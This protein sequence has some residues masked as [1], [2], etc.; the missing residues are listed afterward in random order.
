MLD[1]ANKYV[2]VMA[3]IAPK[4]SGKLAASFK[5]RK[6]KENAR[7]LN[8]VKY[9]KIVNY[10]NPKRG[11]KPANFVQR[12]D[13]ILADDVVKLLEQGVDE[14]IAKEQLQP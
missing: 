2:A 14:L 7:V 4:H 12:A 1:I 13:A 10:G 11:I 9:A 8:P 5:P 6:Q 3:A